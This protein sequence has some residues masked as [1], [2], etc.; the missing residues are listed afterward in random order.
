MT[1]HWVAGLLAPLAY[2]VLVNGIDDVLID[3]AALFSSVQRRFSADPRHRVP[4]EEELASTPPRLMAIFVA[5]WKEH[6]VIQRM[7][8]NN[9]TKL[10][11]PRVEFFVGAYP[12]DTL[13]VA[14]IRQTM[15]RHANVHL[16]LTPHDGPTSKADNLNWIYQRMLL[17][18]QEHGVR[19]EMILTHDAEDL[20]DPDALRWINYYAQWNDMVQIPV[21]AIKTPFGRLAHGVYCDEFAEFQ[22]KDM[23]ARQLLGGFIPS[24]G[25]GTGFSRVAL[26]MLAEAYSNRIFEPA[27][28]TEDYENGFRIKRLG[29]PQKFVPI[30]VRHGRPIATREYFPLRFRSAVRQRSRWITGITLQ[31]WEFHSAR[32]TLRHFYWFWRDRKGLAGNLITPLANILFVWGL[33]TWSWSQ[34]T[35]HAW[36]LA[37]E[38]SRFYPIYMIGLSIQALQTGVRAVCSARIYGWRFACGVPIRVVVANAINC[39][40]TSR[41]ICI[42]AN[43]K[44]NHR[45]LGWVKTEHAYPSRAA[46][47][48]ER[49][50]LRDV[51]AGSGW[52]AP[53][54]LETAL[55]SR[56]A[57]RRLGEHLVSLG[58]ISEQDLYTALSLQNNLP[59]GK[60]EPE[61]VSLPVT[62]SI[63][64]TI[65][66]RLRVLPFRIAGGE[67]YVAGSELPGEQMHRDI[68]HFSSLEI[69][70]HLVTPTEFEELAEAYLA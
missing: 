5:T 62:R 8:D 11:Y 23:P 26:E 31:S 38:M 4:T 17:H 27:C 33:S 47:M 65:A 18:E 52:I 15:N 49:R 63:P 66:R 41:A 25:V 64:A 14:A 35:H 44:I 43:A 1:H 20:M 9:V 6:K 68:R 42:Y 70:F 55:A 22:F 50:R 7:I 28:L 61:A 10:N 16:A 60:P 19:F 48:T 56:P 34:A 12:N 57:G 40:A 58:M 24:N 2:W 54:Q 51:L 29:L 67:L 53:A 46:L 13:T 59:L 21:L 37:R 45:P 36:L 32:E 30:Q 69:R 39:A 3:I